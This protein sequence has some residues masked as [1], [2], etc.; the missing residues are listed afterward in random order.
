VK[1][2]GKLCFL[3]PEDGSDKFLRKVGSLSKDYMVLSPRGQNSL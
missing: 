3:D 2:G 1:E